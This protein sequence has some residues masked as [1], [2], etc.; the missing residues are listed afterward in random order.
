MEGIPILGHIPPDFVLLTTI[1]TDMLIAAVVQPSRYQLAPQVSTA[2]QIDSHT[3]YTPQTNPKI[4]I[5]ATRPHRRPPIV[6][7]QNHV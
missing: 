4:P 1:D 7:D 6:P 5:N 3:P 2:R